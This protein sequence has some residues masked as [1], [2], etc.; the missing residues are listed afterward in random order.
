MFLVDFLLKLFGI[1][2][3]KKSA[4]SAPAANGNGRGRHGRH[5]RHAGNNRPQQQQKPA[6]AD[7]QKPAQ[8]SR[9]PQ[10][11]S[12]GGQSP[13]GS[14]QQQKQRPPRSQPQPPKG[15]PKPQQPSKPNPA[16]KAVS[17]PL[18]EQGPVT[19]AV[20]PPSPVEKA[21]PEKTEPAPAVSAEEAKAPVAASESAPASDSITSA[22][23]AAED[24][25]R[26]I[27]YVVRADM[28]FTVLVNLL[29]SNGAARTVVFCNKKMAAEDAHRALAV[30]G[31][32]CGLLTGDVNEEDRAY[33]L[34]AF[35]SGE[36]PLVVVTDG[37]D[38]GVHAGAVD[39]VVNY[40]FP[41][42]PA[43]YVRRIGD[44]GKG[45]NAGRVIS[46]A[47]ED[48]SFAIPE[49][50]EHLGTSL[51][52]RVLEDSDPLLAALDAAAVDAEP[53]PEPEPLYTHIEG[54]VP[55]FDAL[56]REG[57]VV[58]GGGTDPRPLPSFETALD[59][60]KTIDEENV[61]LKAA[62]DPDRGGEWAVASAES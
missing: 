60:K 59:P 29:R 62:A 19:V 39:F 34:G 54:G 37:F 48:E 18:S 51:K 38:S 33:V 47:D 22:E 52:C 15:S 44:V 7:R 53:E 40:D 36:I 10:Q 14:N 55:V 4:P 43:D 28:K 32:K 31:F 21:E 26:Q 3:D 35:A 56:G 9:G 16:P 25:A 41:Y 46:F 49:I 13:K 30:E 12:R 61:Y 8:P 2:K 50:E 57:R 27:V 20:P 5:G 1:R 42:E 23:P 11:P 45:E 58:L 24:V 6:Q 17:N